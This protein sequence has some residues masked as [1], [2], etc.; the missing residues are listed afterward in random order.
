MRVVPCEIYSRVVG[1]YAPVNRFNFGKKAEFA[2]RVEYD[3]H[4]SLIHGE[5]IAEG[6]IL[7]KEM[8]R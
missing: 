2:D 4:K 7:P 5:L 3:I 8:A 1:Y 6:V